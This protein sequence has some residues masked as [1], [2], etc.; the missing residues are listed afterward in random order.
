MKN[1]SWLG[2]NQNKCK[3]KTIMLEMKQLREEIKRMF[4]R[5]RVLYNETIKRNV[6]TKRVCI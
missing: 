1:D 6:A 4:K 5:D 3:G 2:K